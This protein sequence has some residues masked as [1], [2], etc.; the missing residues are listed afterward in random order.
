MKL[1]AIIMALMAAVL[2]LSTIGC[3]TR[4][5]YVAEV[6]DGYD[7]ENQTEFVLMNKRVAKSVT[8]AGIQERVL[9]DGRLEVTANVL[10]K[11]RRRIQVQVSCVFKDQNGFST[12]DETSWNTLILTE[13]AQEAVRFMS[14]N[15]KARKYTIRV[16]EAR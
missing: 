15:E 10:S 16:R 9:A 1:S 13:N 7:L 11:D 6:P 2:T 5:A 14:M 4:G 8:V 12:G 3:K